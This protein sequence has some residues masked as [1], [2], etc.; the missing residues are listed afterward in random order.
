MQPAG[1]Y[2]LV[3]EQGSTFDQSVLIV[4]ADNVAIDITTYSL[5]GYIRR[6]YSDT[7]K[8]AEFTI[9]KVSAVNGS[10]NLHLTA[11]TLAAI[12]AGEYVYDVEMYK[13]VDAEVIVY[14]VIKGGFTITEEATK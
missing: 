7:T 4:D 8:T 6:R 12:A 13:T 11:A 1:I 5:R 3:A 10:I 9:T 14:K 2:N